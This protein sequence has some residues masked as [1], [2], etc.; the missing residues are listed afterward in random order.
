M[1]IHWYPLIVAILGLVTFFI[2][3]K[4]PG[5]PT[6]AMV[7]KMLFLAGM[8]AVLIAIGGPVWHP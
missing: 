8:I 5:N 1:T 2:A 6:L 7:G 4:Q 3:Q